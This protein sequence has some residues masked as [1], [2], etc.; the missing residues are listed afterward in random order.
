M[1]PD[2]LLHSLAA[3]PASEPED[4]IKFLYQNAF[5]CGH[6][7]ADQAVCARSILLEMEQTL[8]DDAAPAFEPLGNGLCRLNLRSPAV[9]TLPVG[10]IARMMRATADAF[11]GSPQ[12]FQENLLALRS[13]AAQFGAD[14]QAPD[15]SRLPFTAQALSAALARYAAAGS[16]QPRHSERYRAA[17]APAY[18][19]VFRRYGEALPLLSALEKRLN[20][21]GRATLV[22]DGDCAS[23]KTTLAALLSPLYD[24]N[25]FHMD[26]FFLPYALRTPQRMAEPGGNVHYERFRAQVLAR[27]IAA[28]PFTYG[29]FDCHTGATTEVAVTPRPVA[30]IEGSYA[31]HPAL[32]TAYA[33]LDAVRAL[34]TVDPAQQRERIRQRNGEAMLAR[35][36]NEWIPLEIQYFKAYHQSREDQWTLPSQLHEEDIPNGEDA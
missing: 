15:R 1:K 32:D 34:L 16:P 36:Q 25:V 29:A 6:A 31:L 7:L 9:R 27:L 30:L 20:T 13:L 2:F 8:P 14:T 4:A 19:V 28:D 3:K 12:Q 35:F 17:Y 11:H 10:R 24:C 33:A 23:G 5:G 26:D 18:R 21:R 22:L